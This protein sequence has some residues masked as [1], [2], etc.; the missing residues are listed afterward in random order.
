MVWVSYPKGV[1]FSTYVW[2][3]LFLEPSSVYWKAENFLQWTSLF[4]WEFLST[5]LQFS[6]AAQITKFSD[7]YK[8]FSYSSSFVVVCFR[9]TYCHFVHTFCSIWSIFWSSSSE[10]SF[11]P[12]T[13]QDVCNFFPIWIPSLLFLFLFSHGFHCIVETH[14]TFRPRFK[15]EYDLVIHERIIA[16]A[17][18]KLIGCT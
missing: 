12:S 4:T 18:R 13:A 1:K 6:S 10:F 9:P 2:M 7:L 15:G 5:L 17:L 16:H 11:S 8:A 14:C 3:L